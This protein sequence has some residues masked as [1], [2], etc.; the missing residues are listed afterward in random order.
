MP[1][2]LLRWQFGYK[3]EHIVFGFS[4]NIIFNKNDCR[5][6]YLKFAVS[7]TYNILKELTGIKGKIQINILLSNSVILFGFEPKTYPD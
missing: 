2:S 6:S 3:T 4:E 1:E 7:V 5:T